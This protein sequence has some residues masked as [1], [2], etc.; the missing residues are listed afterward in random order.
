MQARYCGGNRRRGKWKSRG[1]RFVTPR[2]LP[3]LQRYPD[4][5]HVRKSRE[6]RGRREDRSSWG[7]PQLL[8]YSRRYLIRLLARQFALLYNITKSAAFHSVMCKS[9]ARTRRRRPTLRN[10]RAR[11]STVAELRQLDKTAAS[12][13]SRLVRINPNDIVAFTSVK[14]SDPSILFIY[15]FIYI[16]Y[17]ILR[18]ILCAIESNKYA[19][20]IRVF[21]VFR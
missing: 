11:L 1:V 16:V 3:M 17:K 6:K 19:I 10:R 4:R 15:L 9:T 20:A 14:R 13:A 8:H 2:Q 21:K 12:E 7:I 18:D 5:C